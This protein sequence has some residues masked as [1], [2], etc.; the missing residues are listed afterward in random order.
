MADEIALGPVSVDPRRAGFKR[1]EST[2]AFN[3]GQDLRQQYVGGAQNAANAALG[4]A[5]DYRESVNDYRQ[6]AA[7]QMYEGQRAI[8]RGA[9]QAAYASGRGVGGAN[10]AGNIAAGQAAGQAMAEMG[11]SQAQ[12]LSDMALQQGNLNMQAQ[13]MSS[14]AAQKAMEAGTLN[15]DRQMKYANYQT[16]MNAAYSQYTKGRNDPAAFRA[17]MMPYVNVEEDPEV[18]AWLLQ[19][20]DRL[21]KHMTG[22][23]NF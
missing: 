13:E 15:S 19:E 17:A 22:T 23:W 16:Q 10:Y 11:T 5:G 2:A 3:Q 21:S 7:R 4:L 14:L 20:I 18:R 9:G 12:M 6:Q 1:P 8:G